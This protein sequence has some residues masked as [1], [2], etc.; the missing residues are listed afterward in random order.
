MTIAQPA[1]FAGALETAILSGEGTTTEATAG[2]LFQA[3]DWYL[4]RTF[5]KGAADVEAF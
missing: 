1:A 2:E 3:E 5:L 4:L